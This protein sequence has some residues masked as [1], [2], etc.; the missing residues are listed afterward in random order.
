MNRKIALRVALILTPIVA[1]VLYAALNWYELEDKKVRT[2]MSEAARRDPY[3]AFTRLLGR[4]GTPAEVAKGPSRLARPPE[5]GVLLLGGRRLAFMTPQRV[6]E[7]DAWV[8][9]GGTLVA[10]AESPGIDD[11]LLERF[12]VEREL[13]A[14]ARERRKAA[15]EAKAK[16]ESSFPR[17]APRQYIASVPWPDPAKPLRV[18]QAGPALRLTGETE[19]P[20]LV[21]VALDGRLMIAMFSAGKG[22]VVALGD[23]RFLTNN[24]I[25]ELDHAEFAARLVSTADAKPA[26]LFLRF[27]SPS[28]SA[29]LKEYAW[30][31]LVTGLLLLFAWLGR[32]V[33]RFGPLEPEPAPV[34]RSLVEHLRASGRYVWS[35]GDAAPLIDAVRDRVWRT[36]LRR[37]GGLK[38]LA[39]S[40]A[41]AAL[42]EIAARPVATVQDAMQGATGHPAAFIAT[43]GALQQVES[44][45]AHRARNP[46]RTR[47]EDQK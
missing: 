7:I 32:I 41:Q 43:A 26:L 47:K 10:L 4:M 8:Q 16:D 25:A 3:L 12:G 18:R 34:R 22:R 6:R 1:F 44:G 42:A 15:R 35:R 5:G 21:T 39:H 45:L 27:E 2:G 28:L 31:V 38:G 11:P 9:R 20:D 29:W 19:P 13:P 17:D 40:K 46:N 14:T 30:P 36:A 24:S 37:R 23:M 33:P